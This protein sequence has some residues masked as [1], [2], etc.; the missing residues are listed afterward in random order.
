MVWSPL[1]SKTRSLFVKPRGRLADLRQGPRVTDTATRR[2]ER[3]ANGELSGKMFSAY[4]PSPR[5]P[6]FMTAI[7]ET[8]S[9]V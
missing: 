4:V 1:R 3:E 2:G 5:G 8:L 6:V 7:K 9:A